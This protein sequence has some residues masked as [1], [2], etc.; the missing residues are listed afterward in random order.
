MR[1]CKVCGSYLKR[2]KEGFWCPKCKKHYPPE[3]APK[4]KK[5]IKSKPS[6]IIVIDERHAEPTKVPVKCPKCGNDKAFY[7]VSSIS[8]EHAGVRRER[9]VEHYKCTK[10]SYSWT[11]EH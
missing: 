11:K 5:A 3:T 8:G 1:F 6:A 2:T 10:C 7:W 9:T 4:E